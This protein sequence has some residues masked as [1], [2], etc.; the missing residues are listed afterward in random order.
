MSAISKKSIAV[1]I[2][3]GV[4][5]LLG[6]VGVVKAQNFL[7]DGTAVLTSE[8]VTQ[9]KAE[10]LAA[11][12]AAAAEAEAEQSIA[13]LFNLECGFGIVGQSEM[14]NCIPV[15][16]YYAVFK[17]AS[18]VLILSG[19]IFDFAL[20]L[21]IDRQYVDQE[22]ITG[23]WKTVRDVSNMAFIFIL[24]YTG[25]ATML[26]FGNW[27][28]TVI[29]VVIIALLVNFS[30]F[31]TKVVIDAGNVLAVGV[32]S[33]LGTADTGTMQ[34]ISANLVQAFEP[35]MFIIESVKYGAL[36]AIIILFV[37]A[38]AAIAVSWILFKVA[39]V[40]IGRLLALWFL[41]IVSPFAFISL[42][43]PKWN[44][45]NDWL[46][47]LLR[48]T[49]VAPMFLL[50]LYVIMKIV[51]DDI[52]GGFVNSGVI[53]GSLITDKLIIPVIVATLIVV[54]LKN[55]KDFAESMA[56][57]FG[58]VGAKMG[59]AV[60]GVVGGVAGGAVLGGAALAGR[61]AI[62]GT[63]Q[64]ID[65]SGKFQGMMGSNNKLARFVGRQGMALTSTASKASFDARGV[66][67]VQK[68]IKQAGLNIGSAGGKGGYAGAVEAR[69]KTQRSADLKVAKR[70]EVSEEAKQNKAR[71]INPMYGAAISSLPGQ[72]TAA[73]N[74]ERE[75]SILKLEHIKAE[76]AARGSAS[77]QALGSV[78]G[79]FDAKLKVAEEATKKMKE[80]KAKPQ[81]TI[82]DNTTGKP[83]VS[84]ALQEAIE[85]EEVALKEVIGAQ[86]ALNTIT[87]SYEK[88]AEVGAVNVAKTVFDSATKNAQK[89][90]S[91]LNETKK[92]IEETNKAVDSWAEKETG[93]RNAA[94]AGDL[95]S[96][97]VRKISNV[98]TLG[99]STHTRQTADK[100]RDIGSADDKAA[101]K[102]AK[103]MAE[104][105]EADQ[106]ER[107][108]YEAEHP[109]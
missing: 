3:V 89:L 8:Q 63:A 39:L 31:F 7:N 34:N 73:K 77:G 59:G 85:A 47:M 48:Q 86:S 84:K 15:I 93:S 90:T 62:G 99:G 92:I 51:H 2:L 50:I 66:G 42:T 44:K 95:Q 64:A 36:D 106:K 82:I 32:Y 65:R 72:T 100:I 22:F 52:L 76:N 98:A 16:I 19:K 25:I 61:T 105:A 88:S 107:A 78:K 4:V 14:V 109:K 33:A 1:S 53:G 58:K 71:E 38:A 41:M 26:G 81:S 45:F 54:A 70:L 97:V 30:L 79:T 74:A 94:F 13:K 68:G 55:A 102:K 11:A 80:E 29:Q 40:F 56:G 10:R 43:F 17:P 103:D 60:M 12:A 83:F 18:W 35:Q 104:R 27:K 37:A 46:D 67:L 91:K 5:F 87:E 69:L 49:F 96:S 20:F 6:G 21:G 101:K 75:E 9:Y 108:K 28:R 57:E 24:L 23:A